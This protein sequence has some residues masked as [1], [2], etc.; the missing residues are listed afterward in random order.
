MGTWKALKNADGKGGI[1]YR[2][3]PTRKHG[4]VPDRYYAAV[5][6][7]QGRTV[8][9]GIGWASEKWTPTKCFNLLATIK[10]NQATGEGPV[11]LAELRELNERKKET[12]RRQTA[13]DER[14]NV[15]FQSFFDDTFLPDAKTRWKPETARKAEEHVKNWINPIVGEI[16]LREIALSHVNRV[17]AKLAG[18]GRSPRMQQYVF[19]TFTMI[20]N[21]ALDH[22]LVNGPCPTKSGSFRLPKVDNERQR[23]LTIDEE[24]KLL[25]ELLKKSK[26]A[27]DMALVSLDA[28]LRFGEIAFLAWGCIDAENGL[29]RVLDT[30]GGRDRNVP[31]TERLKELFKSLVAGEPGELVFP[32]PKSDPGKAPRI[33]GQVPSAFVRAMKESGLNKGVTNPKMRASFHTL[34]HTYASRLVQSGADLYKVQRLLGHSTPVMTA[35]YSK[36]ADDDLRQAVKAMEQDRKIKASKGKVIKMKRKAANRK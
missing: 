10:E 30:K 32:S 4:A 13:A 7:W 12:E 26:Q 35:R 20:W 2:E 11:T 15:S 9:E 17:R 31:M 34:R 25:A 18:A 19:R 5:Y 21:A 3:H 6:W 24:K 8:S 36:L 22:G 14:L 1:R 33:Q 23:Y 27:H 28:G 29:I 16:P